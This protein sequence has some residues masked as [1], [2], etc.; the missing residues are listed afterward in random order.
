[1]IA[2]LTL[3]WLALRP[4][5]LYV[6]RICEENTLSL[7]HGQTSQIAVADSGDWALRVPVEDVHE[8]EG[9]LVRVHSIDF[10][11]PVD[12]VALFTFSWPVFWALAVAAPD[13][14]AN[15]RALLIGTA[16]LGVIEPLLLLIFIEIDTRTVLTQWHP[17]DK[18][19]MAA[20]LREYGTYVNNNVMPFFAPIALA[21]AIHPG[22][23]SLFSFS[24]KSEKPG[25]QSR[26]NARR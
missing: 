11:I 19:G 13:F 23:R 16:A 22:L 17:A 9:K 1:M 26:R 18:A 10:T 3:W 12:D 20:W 24:V 14:K 15:W 5:L 25:Q 6:L 8:E 4:P 7:I 21:V 2:L